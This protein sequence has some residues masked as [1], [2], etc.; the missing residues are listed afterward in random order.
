MES[1]CEMTL[2]LTTMYLILAISWISPPSGNPFSVTNTGTLLY[3]FLIQFSNF[4]NP[5]GAIC[6]CKQLR[7]RVPELQSKLICSVRGLR[8]KLISSVRGLRSKLISSV[9]GLRS[10]LISS[11]CGLRSKLICSVRGL[12]SKLIVVF[13]DYDRN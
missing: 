1:H 5:H 6:K 9:R 4:R 13:V 12:R 8:S 10:K 7:V 3:S 11:V 2:L